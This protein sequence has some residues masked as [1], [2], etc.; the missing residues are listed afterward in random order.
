MTSHFAH[1]P[2]TLR[3]Q[4]THNSTPQFEDNK[5]KIVE[6]EADGHCLYRAIGH[7]LNKSHEQVR[8]LAADFLTADADSFAPFLSEEDGTFEEYVSKVRSSADWGGEL[9]LRAL[10][11]GLKR[12]I[13]IYNSS[14]T[15]ILIG[16]EF[17]EAGEMK[18]SYHRYYY[19]LGEHYNIVGSK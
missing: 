15:P 12:R 17:S 10:S 3:P 7:Y 14:K 1:T 2:S 11:N 4:F 6:V 18:V 9:E 19:D 5:L 13:T 8:S 16:E